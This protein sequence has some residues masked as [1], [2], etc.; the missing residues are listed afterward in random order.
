MMGLK[1][2]L[3]A[4]AACA[5]SVVVAACGGSDARSAA[6]DEACSEVSEA[7]AGEAAPKLLLSAKLLSRVR[8]RAQSND[9]DWL[10]LRTACEAWSGATVNAPS[11]AKYGPAPTIASGYQGDGY[12]APV[13]SLALC[14][15]TMLG[16][17]S[18]AAAKYG[19]AGA[20]VLEAM[21]TPESQGGA[22]PPTDH[23]Y[24]I[25]NYGVGMA[26]GYDWLAPAV[27]ATQ[28]AR[29]VAALDNWIS[30]Y[31]KQ[32]FSK[33]HPIANYFVGYLLAK[34]Y[35]GLTFEGVDPKGAVWWGDVS[36]R[37]WE[38][39]VKPQF[40]SY[41]QGGGWPEGWGYG[42]RAVRGIAEFYWALKTAKNLDLQAQLPQVADQAVYINY[43]AWPALNRMDDQGTVRAGNALAPSPALATALATALWQL[44]DPSAPMATD[45]A[46][47]VLA[48]APDDREPWLKFLYWDPTL[49]KAAH[50]TRP[51]SYLAKGPGHAA[52]RST[53]DHDA[54]WGALSG[55]RY[56][57]APASGEQMF[58]SGGIAVV[59]GGE[60]LLVN[61]TGWIP[62]TAATAGENFVYTDGFAKGGRRLYNTFFVDDPSNIY[63]PGQNMLDPA[64]SKAKLD[65]F[66]DGG[67][68]VRVRASGLEDQYGTGGAKPVQSFTRD[69]VYVRPGT[70]VIHDRTTVASAGA[71]QWM[72]FHVSSTPSTEPTSDPTHRRFGVSGKSGKLGS[73]TTMLPH[74]ISPKLVALPGGAVRI[75]AHAPIKQASQQWLSVAVASPQ[76]AAQTRLSA[77]DGNV[78]SGAML[79]VELHE[80]KNQVVLFAS[81]PAAPPTSVQYTVA[82]SAAGNHV[83][84]D[85]APSASG[86][87]VTTTAAGT[88]LTVSVTIGGPFKPSS[89]GV[90]EFEL[91]SSGQLSQPTTPPPTAD[92]GGGSGSGGASGDEPGPAGAGGASSGGEPADPGGAGC[93]AQATNCAVKEPEL[94]M[95][96]E[97]GLVPLPVSFENPC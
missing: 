64:V 69:L 63:N 81:D 27:S 74:D 31:D 37:L 95:G 60:P 7:L 47:H 72:A 57:N 76:N 4:V 11:G 19:A 70:F 12:L 5:A 43:F 83:L 86:Y 33:D 22:K 28:R 68:Y 45:F 50:E 46:A 55:A 84:V 79:G 30:W 89:D 51:T 80:A 65:R 2:R 35:A 25:R 96:G 85:L 3:L 23:G 92:E 42:P 21:S 16:I 77:A 94:P 36:S 73:I 1:Q 18:A 67:H 44:G 39:I 91:T 17:D 41:M 13:L 38:K 29:V 93:V 62:H 75:E 59:V 88:A 87:A 71:D 54:V 8:E 10:S 61:A 49:P 40:T 82:P 6:D 66:E 26:L 14:Y 52:M 97:P 32:G 90:L 9:P 24:G 34:T 56:I 58:N 78:L 53:W 15:R 20:K 48:A